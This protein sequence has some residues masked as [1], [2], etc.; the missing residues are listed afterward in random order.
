[1]DTPTHTYI[2]ERERIFLQCGHV[3]MH[4]CWKHLIQVSCQEIDDQFQCSNDWLLCSLLLNLL[5]YELNESIIV[6]PFLSVCL[7]SLSVCLPV[8]LSLSASVSPSLDVC[9]YVC[10]CVH[11][12]LCTDNYVHLCKCVLWWLVSIVSLTHLSRDNL[13]LRM[14]CEAFS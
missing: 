9:I 13:N 8:S 11:T 1:M 10:L 14:A 12:Y 6:F 3:C 7:S 4:V 2:Y 5:P